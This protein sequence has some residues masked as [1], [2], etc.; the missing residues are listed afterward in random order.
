MYY[1]DMNIKKELGNKIKR[2]RQQ[3][4]I[5]QEQLAEMANISIRT[6]GGIEIG[7]N[8]MTAQ[9]MERLLECLDTPLNEL[10]NAEHLRPTNEL[11]EQLHEI[12]NSVKDDSDKIEELYKVVKAIVT[13]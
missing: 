8:F 7:K 4:G 10:F 6:L 1:K 2:L 9:T 13:I 12:I 11:V 3:K 5:T